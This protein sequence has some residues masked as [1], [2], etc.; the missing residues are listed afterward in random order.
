MTDQESSFSRKTRYLALAALLLAVL[1]LLAQCAHV[2]EAQAPRHCCPPP[3]GLLKSPLSLQAPP[4][5]P[6]RKTAPEAPAPAPQALS[7]A[8]AAQPLFAPGSAPSPERPDGAPSPER[9]DGAPS[10]ERPDT[11]AIVL[12]AVEP[13]AAAAASAQET[14][15]YESLGAFALDPLPAIGPWVQVVSVVPEPATWA[16][17]AMGLGGLCG[18]RRRPAPTQAQRMD[19]KE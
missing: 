10:P 7:W 15:S 13:A 1:A 6:V 8:E 19:S 11:F 4:A 18:L 3:A 9:P 14:E 2:L 16:M 5:A 12:Y 17:L